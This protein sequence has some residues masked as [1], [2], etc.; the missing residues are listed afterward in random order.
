MKVK[1]D[2]E[3]RDVLVAFL[4]GR[5]YVFCL[6]HRILGAEPEKELLDTVSSDSSLQTVLLFDSDDS[7]AAVELHQILRDCRFAEPER[8]ERMRDEYT[9]LFIG[10]ERLSAAP[11]ESVYTTRERALFQESTLGVRGWYRKYQYLPEKYPRVADDHISLMTHFL[12][13]TSGRAAA[14]LKRDDLN[15]CRDILAD[16]KQFEKEHLL[17]WVL[18]YADDIRASETREFYPQFVKAAA[19]F[20]K[21]DNQI[22]DE[23]ID[24]LSV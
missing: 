12:S 1:M 15:R 6:L 7:K 2:D 14:C 23:L 5:E 13:M 4:R 16:Q 21:Y 18:S 20:I 22:I 24:N 10:P 3:I 19:D 17:N 8:V 9:R 11:W